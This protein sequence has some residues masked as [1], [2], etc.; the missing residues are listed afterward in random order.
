MERTEV[1]RESRASTRCWSVGRGWTWKSQTFCCSHVFCRLH[2]F[3]VHRAHAASHF[4][5]LRACDL[6][7]DRLV[8]GPVEAHGT[9]FVR[10]DGAPSALSGGVE[11]AP[12]RRAWAVEAE[13]QAHR[14]QPDRRAASSPAWPTV[15]YAPRAGSRRRTG[16]RRRKRRG[17]G[18]IRQ[19][20]GLAYQRGGRKR[21]AGTSGKIRRRPRAS[22]QA[23]P[24]F[25]FSRS[26]STTGGGTNFETSPPQRCTSRTT[27]ELTNVCSSEGVR[28][29]VSTSGAS[30]RLA[31]AMRNS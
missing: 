5:I 11:D 26:A 14:L 1:S 12:R 3:C 7:V 20:R 31:K 25:L 16:S 10:G 27:V 13:R 22:E 19:R 4:T 9:V 24:Y 21:R 18:R 6:V 23:I 30:F 29:I 17:E 28:K 2:A 15:S 8:R